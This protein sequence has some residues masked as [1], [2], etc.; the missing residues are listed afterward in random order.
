LWRGMVQLLLGT[1][2]VAFDGQRLAR[3]GGT[4]AP[5]VLRETGR[6]PSPADN[7]AAG[8]RLVVRAL[9]QTTAAIPEGLLGPSERRVQRHVREGMDGVRVVDSRL[10]TGGFALL[11]DRASYSVPLL[12]SALAQEFRDQDHRGGRV[13]R[14]RK[15]TLQVPPVPRRPHPMEHTR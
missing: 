4:E 2:L 10:A 6:G 11:V 3:R 7:V 14:P 9:R 15:S 8:S 1:N 13:R 12:A 5:A